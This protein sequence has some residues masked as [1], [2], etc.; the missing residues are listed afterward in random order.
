MKRKNYRAQTDRESLG[1]TQQ[2]I[3][4]IL[5]VSRSHLSHHEGFRRHLP[6]GA[7]LRLSEM[8]LYMLSPEAKTF[9]ALDKIECE[10]DKTKNILE[11]RIKENEFQLRVIMR[12]IETAQAKF[13]K[14]KNAIQLMSFLNSPE[15]A[16]K[17]A[18]PE[19]LS[20]IES[21]AIIKFKK[22]K[23]ELSLLLIDMELLQ[24]QQECYVKAL[25]K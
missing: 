5:N 7:G 20:L 24:L 10:D 3:A 6:S 19:T 18:K 25:K 22:A 17:A 2:E 1:L 14:C 23:S 8:I 4:L 13:D 15:E 9:K 12:K 21:V 11:K 16:K